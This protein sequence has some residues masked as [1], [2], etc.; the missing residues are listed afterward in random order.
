[1]SLLKIRSY[2]TRY[3]C[4]CKNTLNLFTTYYNLLID[5]SYRLT[6]RTLDF[7]SNNVG[8]IPASLTILLKKL[9]N[10]PHRTSKSFYYR[11]NFKT[12]IAPSS[13]ASTRPHL[14]PSKGNLESS[15][16]LVKQSYL[17]LTWFKFVYMKR[18]NFMNCSRITFF[19]KPSRR[20]RFTL[21]KAP[22][23]HKT[24]SQEQYIYKYYNIVISLNIRIV[25]LNY[26][27]LSVN[28][29]LWILLLIR[30]S[31]FFFETN[32]FF[33][34]KLSLRFPVRDTKYFKI[35]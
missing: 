1:M 15:R 18:D 27:I 16:L 33:L 21:V 19:I 30:S 9:Y 7:H 20:K 25:G 13:L 26:S 32:L 24:F 8:S 22:M 29:V 14:K 3:R 4:S 5:S 10:K 17:V 12:I 11:F 28:H 34:Q 35:N 31:L 23:A 6:V 2:K